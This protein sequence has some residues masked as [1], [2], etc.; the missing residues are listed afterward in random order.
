M[1]NEDIESLVKKYQEIQESLQ[2]I[3]IE[4]E[5]YKAQIKLLDSSKS[6]I[7]NSNGKIFKYIGNVLVETD[8]E[9]AIKEIDESS[10][11]LQLRLSTI[12][13]SYQELS[14]Q[15]KELR[16]KLN[17]YVKSNKQ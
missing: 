6:A 4:R 8:K 5:Q 1:N 12:E 11:L 15:E 17:S 16:E 2:N 13:K 7:Q 14:K 10:E 3:V 9:S